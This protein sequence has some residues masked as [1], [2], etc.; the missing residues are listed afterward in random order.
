MQAAHVC[1]TFGDQRHGFRQR[2][3]GQGA[4]HEGGFH[5]AGR[6]VI[7][8]QRVHHA[9]AHK[10]KHRDVAGVARSP[11]YIGRSGDDPH[12]VHSR[13]A[14]CVDVDRKFANVDAVAD[15][16]VDL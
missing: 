12:A 13:R 16:L 2:N 8:G 4:G 11:R 14:G 3:A 10:I 7:A 5:Q 6:H 9:S 15:V 1:R